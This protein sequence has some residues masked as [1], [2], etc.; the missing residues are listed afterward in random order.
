MPIKDMTGLRFERLR[1]IERGPSD[2]NGNARWH[3]ICDCG[4]KTLSSGFT[5]RNGQAKSCGCLT[6]DQL[7]ARATKHRKHR[8]PEWRCWASMRGRCQNPNSKKWHLYG[9][10]GITVCERWNDFENFYADMGPRPSLRHSID[11][12]NGNGNYEPRNCRWALPKEQANN[13]T[14]NRM[15]VYRG[16]TMTLAQA[17]DL[18]G[19]IVT[20]SKAIERLGREWSVEDAVELPSNKAYGNQFIRRLPAGLVAVGTQIS[21]E[22]KS[23]MESACRSRGIS[24]SE[25]LRSLIEKGVTLSEAPQ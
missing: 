11:R 16:E 13:T 1:V 19:N 21:P 25:F 12:I 6:T 5:L 22:L 8:T 3:C 4:N 24:V 9:G 14:Q 23:A 20:H 17:L 10:K 18:A 7:R 2:T 15:V